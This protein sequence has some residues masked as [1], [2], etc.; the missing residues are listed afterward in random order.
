MTI[1]WHNP[2]CAKSRETLKLLEDAG[3]EPTV[4]QYLKQPPDTEEIVEALQLLRV[5]AIE[6]VRTNEDIFDEL[7]L[8]DADDEALVEAM[9][10][11]PILI[12]RP[13]VFHEGRAAIGRP[14]EKVR[15]IL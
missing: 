2:R 8:A 14:P 12:E 3:L 10:A 9:A 5:H 15:E 11:H 6:L 13:I 1:I 7:D 4:R